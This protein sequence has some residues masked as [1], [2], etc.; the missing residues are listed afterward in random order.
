MRN[1]T[2]RRKINQHNKILVE[3]LIAGISFAT[4]ILGLFVIAYGLQT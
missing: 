2:E 3:S 4:I 1:N